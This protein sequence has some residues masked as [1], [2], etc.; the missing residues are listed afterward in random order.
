MARRTVNHRL[1]IQL[2]FQLLAALQL[3]GGDRP[4]RIEHLIQRPQLFFR[5]PMAF[6]APFHE[7]RPLLPHQLH[8][9]DLAVAAGA[10]DAFVHM[11]RMVEV[12]M[13]GEPMDAIPFDGLI[14]LIACADRCEHFR[15][16]PDLLVAIHASLGRRHASIG[17][18]FHRR[19]AESAIDA[20][21]GNVLLMA[22]R[23]RLI[24]DDSGIGHIAGPHKDR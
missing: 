11:H 5:C 23:D 16:N 21:C 18:G 15:A 1:D 2:L 7:Q 20:K 14:V 22:E 4:F 10:T 13:I 3:I 6:Q 24:A 9:I 8:L 19:M 12:H 17:G